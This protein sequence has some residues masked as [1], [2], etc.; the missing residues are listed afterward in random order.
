MTKTSPPRL[1]LVAPSGC[2]P[3]TATADAAAQFF[4]RRG[5]QVQAGES[6]FARATRFAGPDELRLHDLQQYAADP[7]VDIVIAA[8]GGYGLSRLLDRIDYETIHRAGRIIVGLSDFTAFNLAYLA[9]AGG[10]SFQGPTAGDFAVARPDPFTVEH[11]FAAISEPEHRLEFDG[12]GPDCDVKG[13]LW[14]GNLALVTA[15]VGTPYLPRLRGGVLF[16]EDVNEPAYRI[17][18][19]LYQLLHAGVLA[20]CRAV[21]LGDFSP[22]PAQPN[23]NGFDLAQ[24][25]SQLRA[26]SGVPILTGLPFGHVPRKLTLPV[27]AKAALRARCGRISLAFS[28]HPTLCR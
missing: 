7:H 17:E 6:C 1:A 18:R 26:Q 14:G 19:M 15:L 23:D 9:R 8:R 25:I 13:V 10:V 5:W 20:R 16:L 24:A 3:D 11:F 22:V 12:D 28:G 27:G 4:A 21:L 2:L